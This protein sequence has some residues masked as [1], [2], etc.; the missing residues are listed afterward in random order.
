MIRAET[1]RRYLVPHESHLSRV[2]I[3]VILQLHIDKI[4]MQVD[5]LSFSP[6]SRSDDRRFRHKLNYLELINIYLGFIRLIIWGRRKL[7]HRIVLLFLQGAHDCFMLTVIKI[8]TFHYISVR[9]LSI[10]F[11]TWISSWYFNATLLT[12]VCHLAYLEKIFGTFLANFALVLPSSLLGCKIAWICKRVLL[13]LWHVPWGL[14]LDKIVITVTLMIIIVDVYRLLLYVLEKFVPRVALAIIIQ[15]IATRLLPWKSLF[16]RCKVLTFVRIFG[17]SHNC[18]NSGFTEWAVKNGTWKL[19][20]FNFL[21]FHFQRVFNIFILFCGHHFF[22]IFLT[23][24]IFSWALFPRSAL[25]L[26]LNMFHQVL[27]LI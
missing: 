22:H 7:C 27:E 25:D 15:D 14:M 18:Y 26:I 21:V 2:K 3:L 23:N 12:T 5:L 10:L 19:L 13:C 17:S 20:S 9:C 4:V 11:C 16:H 1:L 8:V 24:N 6:L